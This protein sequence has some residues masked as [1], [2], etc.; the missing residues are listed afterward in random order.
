MTNS[1][2][3]QLGAIAFLTVLLLAVNIAGGILNELITG[4][5]CGSGVN[6]SGQAAQEAF[7]LS[8][9]LCKDVAAEGVVLLK[10]DNDTL[11]LTKSEVS[12]VN[13]FGWRSID[14]AWIGGAS[15]SVNGN[16]NTVRQKIKPILTA[17][18]ENGIETNEELTSIYEKFCNV[19]DGKALNDGEK[20]FLL[21]EPSP[22][23]Y[24]NEVIAKAKEFSSTAIVVLGRQGGEGQDLPKWQWKYPSTDVK[25]MVTDRTYLDISSEEEGML[26]VVTANFEKVIVIVNSCNG[27]NY[28]FLEKYENIGACLTL[29]GS[30]QSGAYSIVKIMYGKITPSGKT[31]TTSPYD[32]T[33]N[34]T[35]FNH[36][37]DATSFNITYAEDIYFGYK[38]YE[39]ADE[40]GYW[41]DSSI[42]ITVK[43]KDGTTL[44]KKKNGYEAVVQYPFGFGLS[45]TS[46]D[47]EVTEIPADKSIN[48]NN[49]ISIKVKVT[50]TGEARGKDVVE[51]YASAPYTK[52]GIEKSSVTLV[53]FA[54]TTTLDPGAS[55][56]LT[57][58]FNPYDMASYDCYDK[59]GNGFFGYELEKGNYVL[60]LRTS[61]HT[62]KGCDNDEITFTLQ[63][64]I[65]FDKDPTTGETVEN[66][67]TNYTLGGAE[68][69]AYASYAIDGSDF[70]GEKVKYLTRSDF[71]GTFPV[72]RDIKRANESVA[73]YTYS[74]YAATEMPKTEEDNGLLLYV[75]KDGGKATKDELLNGENLKINEELVL[76]LGASY[77][78]PD[79][80]KLLN[81]L[82]ISDME[83]LI[84]LG[85]YRT[86]EIESVGK[87]YM[88]DNDGGSGLNRHI[89]EGD[90][91]TGYDSGAR[92]SWTLFPSTTLLA[93]SWN[94][95][96]A[97]EYGLGIA[98]EAVSTG[99]DGWY[100]P[101]CNMLR[102]PF[103]GRCSEYCSEDPIISGYI[104]A[105]Q[106]KGSMANGMY[107]YVKHFA[108]NE[109]E[110]SRG[111]LNTFLTEQNMRENYLKPYEI[112]VKVGGTCGIMSA[113]N[114]IGSVRAM[115]NRALLTDVLRTEWGFRGA[116]ITDYYGGDM[117]PK[118]GVYAGNDL[119][120]TGWG[121]SA[122]FSIGSDKTSAY[123]A[124][125]SAKNILYMKCR[126][127]YVSKNHDNTLDTIKANTDL[128]VV[129]NIPFR[130]W[131]PVLVCVDVMALSWLGF[132]AYTVSEKK[133]KDLKFNV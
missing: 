72:E 27:F 47:W 130:W 81:Q 117:N 5:L 34:P 62:K 70:A 123:Y 133:D 3:I 46:F 60:S 40:E 90:T 86:R 121:G 91:N 63:E 28:S 49:P 128:I 39:T 111:G 109:T 16:N 119:M 116:V 45:Y 99:L 10:N 57:L 24:T 82:S 30:G 78:D 51:L 11:P 100:S 15:G 129:R 127:Y 23:V 112:T 104:T 102:S 65:K 20:F 76:K 75:K 120:L 105:Y 38:W 41:A 74:G 101:S 13:V 68:K 107:T 118:Q 114:R 80:D 32:F 64:A 89:Q 122:G 110:T 22:S 36:P 73:G 33:T 18:E 126:A 124:R 4:F 8:D 92:S 26:D 87:K 132:W 37:D 19:G 55:E 21:K 9:E 113:F 131:I 93:S 43:K 44:A 1:K 54:K 77:D 85:G 66:R 103:D 29:S 25:D 96:L 12:A 97:Y 56:T 88:L 125:I 7:A 2:K 115:G 53:A 106:V 69:K 52:G 94:V 50:N 17:L 31:T 83:T 35:Y 48:G 61:S 14:V 71:K 67:F 98:N 95:R 84:N 6:M 42:D 108:V 79:W 58:T 59:N